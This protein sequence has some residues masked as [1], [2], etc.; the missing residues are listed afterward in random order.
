M[1]LAQER[2]PSPGRK[3]NYCKNA[4]LTK[5]DLALKDFDYTK[6]VLLVDKELNRTE[7]RAK[8]GGE[9]AKGKH[10]IEIS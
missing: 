10:K 5:R 4:L 8:W 2:A 7:G 1:R 6:N 3:G 9:W